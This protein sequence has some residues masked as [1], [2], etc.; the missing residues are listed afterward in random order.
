MP[1]FLFL[2]IVDNDAHVLSLLMISDETHFD[3]SG[4]VIEQNFWYLAEGHP[5][6]LHEQQLE[7]YLPCTSNRSQK[8]LLVC[9]VSSVS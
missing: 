4:Y 9:P 5:I 6:K 2:E 1:Q 3:F 7:F 8:I